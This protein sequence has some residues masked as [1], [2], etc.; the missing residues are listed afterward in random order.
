MFSCRQNL[1][2]RFGNV[3]LSSCNNKDWFFPTN[4]SLDVSVGFGTKCLYFTPCNENNKY[5]IS[6]SVIRKIFH[7]YH[8]SFLCARICEKVDAG[9]WMN[10]RQYN[11][12]WNIQHFQWK[13]EGWL[14]IVAAFLYIP[15]RLIATHFRL[16]AEYYEFMTQRKA[17]RNASKSRTKTMATKRGPPPRMPCARFFLPNMNLKIAALG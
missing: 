6:D 14:H 10:V 5:L 4:G 16:R 12:K 17:G 3:F 15:A 1:S 7:K 2:L 8:Q 13:L 11:G 9:K